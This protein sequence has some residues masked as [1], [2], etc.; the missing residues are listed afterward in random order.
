MHLPEQHMRPPM[1]F[2]WLSLN[3]NRTIAG[4]RLEQSFVI[5]L[6]I[7]LSNSMAKLRRHSLTAALFSINQNARK[8]R[9]NIDSQMQSLARETEL[10]LRNRHDRLTACRYSKQ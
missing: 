2:W 1:A 6:C 4:A 7:L 5:A 3:E 8:Y 10:I 9:I